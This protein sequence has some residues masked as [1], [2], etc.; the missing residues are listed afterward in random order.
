M[1][2]FLCLTLL[3]LAVAAGERDGANAHPRRWT[4]ARG[5]AS[6]SCVSHA[7]PVESLGEVLWTFKPSA[8][9]AHTPLTWD[10]TGFLRI[11]TD[12]VAIDLDTGKR[13]AAQAVG[14]VDAMA[15]G[16]GAAILLQ[17]GEFQ[18]WRRDKSA[19]RKRW[20]FAAG[21]DASAP[22]IEGNEIYATAGGKLLRLRAGSDKPVWAQGAKCFGSP[23]LLGEE[24]YA[25][26]TGASGNAALV[27]RARL[28]GAERARV[29]L[30][31]GGQ[32]GS[33]ALNRGH[34]CVRIDDRWVLIRRRLKDGTVE[35]DKP[36]SI[37]LDAEPLIY[38][39]AVIGVGGPAG[40]LML[41]RHGAKGNI[42]NPLIKPKERPEL[43]K[44]AGMPMSM[45]DVF[46][47]SLW[48]AEIDSNRIRWHLHERPDRAILDAGVSQRPVPADDER[49]LIV[50]ADGKRIICIKPE[51]IGS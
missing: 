25:L 11:G 40:A 19:F 6:Q 24:V 33:V 23:A 47:C 43:F 8:P 7:A 21:A 30:G 20:S 18:Q 49:L 5:P 31:K 22:C 9:I 17:N 34:V 28:D 15:L 35:L 27:A 38:S 1:R 44:G 46:S 2:T 4:H 29:D 26:E 45:Q 42:Q 36:W 51:V 32:A 14:A 12:L 48:T 13:V 16:E 3:A 50:S 10:G 41:Y 37:Q 39:R